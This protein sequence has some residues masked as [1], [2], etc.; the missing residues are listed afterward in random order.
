MHLFFCYGV[1]ELNLRSVKKHALN[2]LPF[3]ERVGG[4]FSIQPITDDRRIQ[5]VRVG[6]VYTQLMGAT[7]LRKEIHE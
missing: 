4:G 5:S 2:S 3:R 1:N 7:G 6:G